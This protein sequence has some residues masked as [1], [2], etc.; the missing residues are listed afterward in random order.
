M[1]GRVLRYLSGLAGN[2]P[3]C[4]GFAYDSKMARAQRMIMFQNREQHRS[5]NY[6][7][8]GNGRLKKAYARVIRETRAIFGP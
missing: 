1:A 6:K 5:P 8:P 2:N 7:H 3:A 4:L